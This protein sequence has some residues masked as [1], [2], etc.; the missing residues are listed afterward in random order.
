MVPTA[1]SLSLLAILKHSCIWEQRW[2]Q[3]IVAGRL[4]TDGW[5]DQESDEPD[6]DFLV[7]EQDTV[8]EWLARYRQAAAESRGIVAARGLDDACG[9]PEVVDCNVRWVLLHLIGETARHAGH[10]D[11]LRETLDGSRGT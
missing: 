6:D 3:G 4:L 7:G 9:R 2:F 8:A 11:I 5:P 1:S 10:A